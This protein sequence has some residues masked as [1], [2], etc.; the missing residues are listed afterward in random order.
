MVARRQGQYERQFPGAADDQRERVCA[1]C[2]GYINF[3][4]RVMYPVQAPQQGNG[5]G[6]AVIQVIRQIDKCQ[7]HDDEQPAPGDIQPVQ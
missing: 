3:R 6:H 7:A 5:M 2:R 1:Q 4:V